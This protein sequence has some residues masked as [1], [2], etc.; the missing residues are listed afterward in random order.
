MT[1][2]VYEEPGVTAILKSKTT[3][4]QTRSTPRSNSEKDADTKTSAIST[5]VSNE[6]SSDLG[7]AN[8]DLTNAPDIPESKSRRLLELRLLHNYLAN[9]SQPFHGSQSEDVKAIWSVH[10]PQLAMKHENL[11]YTIFAGSALHLLRSSPNDSE[12]SAARQSYLG[13]ALREQRN[14]VSKLNSENADALCFSSVMILIDTFA[15]LHGR[16]LE[17]YSPPMEW[18]EMGRG[19]GAVFSIVLK[20]VPDNK[21]AKIMVLVNASPSFDTGDELHAEENR[22]SF[23]GLLNQN[24]QA[25]QDPTEI[26][27]V[28]TREVY[29][30]TLSIIGS[31]ERAVNNNEPIFGVARRLLT[32]VFFIS[33]RFVEFVEQRRPRALVILAHYFAFAAQYK[34]VWWIGDSA[35]REIRAIQTV[36]P[37]EWQEY[38]HWPLSIA[39]APLD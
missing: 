20:S 18:L 14:A 32:F 35:E 19:A 22:K 7:L 29:A 11:L 17:P 24:L 36:L 13:M 34:S 38:M 4:R 33:K 39:G 25:S 26:L 2:C 3:R 12:L 15:T 23:I 27:D 31:I 6:T 16:V 9:L 5:P 10:V 8:I 28:E 30:D 1:P 21:T 37:R